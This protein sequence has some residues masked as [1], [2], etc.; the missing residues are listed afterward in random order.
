MRG[1]LGSP[2]TIYR[3]KGSIGERIKIYPTLII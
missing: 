3:F 1:V 2:E